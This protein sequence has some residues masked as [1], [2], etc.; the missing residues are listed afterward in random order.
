MACLVAGLPSGR[1]GE[2]SDEDSAD[3]VQ[4]RTSS[5]IVILGL[6]TARHKMAIE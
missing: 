4:R 1:A 3:E 2:D 6:G 5:R